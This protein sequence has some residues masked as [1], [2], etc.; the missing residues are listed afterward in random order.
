[1]TNYDA[2]RRFEWAARDHLQALGFWVTRAAGSKTKVDLIAVRTGE[3]L[4]VQCKR[5]ALPSPFERRQLLALA[6]CLPGV[7]VP[8]IARK[9]PRGTPV[10]IEILT[11]PGPG[12]RLP[13]DTTIEGDAH[14]RQ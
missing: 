4:F 1:M 2:G 12:D 13:Y 7:A 3:V 11:G 9:G 14:V 10:A 8:A 6:E 5:T